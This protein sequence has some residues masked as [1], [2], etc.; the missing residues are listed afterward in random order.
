MAP[1]FL[2]FLALAASLTLDLP[3]FF[4]ARGSSASF[5]FFAFDRGAGGGH[6]PPRSASARTGR[7][8]AASAATV[9]AASTARARTIVA[10]QLLRVAQ[11]GVA[12]LQSRCD[13]SLRPQTKC[14]GSLHHLIAEIPLLGAY[15]SVQRPLH[16]L[17]CVEISVLVCYW[18]LAALFNSALRS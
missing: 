4:G 16:N 8:R 10:P 2:A 6:E 7:G 3:F 12:G 15:C 18:T 11:S 17:K 1:R 9:K 5:T 14:A 13:T